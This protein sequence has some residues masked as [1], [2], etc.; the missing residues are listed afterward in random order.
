MNAKIFEQLFAVL[1]E[2][3]VP[4]SVVVVDNIP[5]HSRRSKVQTQVLKKYKIQNWI[6]KKQIFYEKEDV[7]VELCRL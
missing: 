2:K 1:L 3:F 7:K 6:K 4:R 5:H